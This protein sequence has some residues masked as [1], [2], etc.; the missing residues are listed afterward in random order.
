MLIPSLVMGGLV[1]RASGLLLQLLAQ[2]TGDGGF[3]EDCRKTTECITPGVY[4]MVY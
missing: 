3:F 1:G 2:A 4:A